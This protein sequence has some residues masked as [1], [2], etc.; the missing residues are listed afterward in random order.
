MS[1]VN[2]YQPD[3]KQCAEQFKAYSGTLSNIR[4]V[5][6]LSTWKRKLDKTK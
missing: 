3:T 2:N 1:W 6:K 4:N 5:G